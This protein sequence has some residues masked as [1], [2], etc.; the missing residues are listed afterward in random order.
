MK[1]SIKA[2]GLLLLILTVALS[3]FAIRPPDPKP[4]PRPDLEF[5]VS[6]KNLSFDAAGGSKAVSVTARNISWGIVAA[7]ASWLTAT[8]TKSGV[9]LKATKNTSTSSRTTT[10]TLGKGKTLAKV[11]ITQKGA[12]GKAV[13]PDLDIASGKSVELFTVNGVSFEMVRV[14]GGSFM[15]GSNDG[16]REKPIHLE[17]VKTFWIGRT[18]V[19][20]ALWEAVMGSN[21][22]YFKGSNLPVE[23]VSWDDCQE[24][25]ERLNRKTGKKFRLPSDAEWEYAA[26]GGN[27]SAGYKYSGSNDIGRVAWYDDN[28]NGNTHPVAS[29]LDN[30]LGLYDMS[31]NVWEWCQDCWRKNYSAAYDCSYR[32]FRGGSWNSSATRCRVAYRRNNSPGNRYGNVG[33]RLAL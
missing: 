5:S 24:F 2:I 33:V 25:I 9:Q 12:A 30:E 20:Q 8:K 29:K 7:P 15:M 22:S 26:R 10:I 3:A 21:P 4:D 31:G 18:E 16:R 19:T 13:N 17:T 1:T 11:T 32:V 23:N 28:S 14:D 27:R 6:P